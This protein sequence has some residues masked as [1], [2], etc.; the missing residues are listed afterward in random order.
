[1]ARVV[2][3]YSHIKRYV[4]ELE[5]GIYLAKIDATRAKTLEEDDRG[6][7]F[8][9]DFTLLEGPEEGGRLG[10]RIYVNGEMA[11]TCDQLEKALGLKA[12]FDTYADLH[13]KEVRIQT[14]MRES[15]GKWYVNVWRI[16]PAGDRGAAALPVN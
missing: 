6:T 2:P 5:D 4:Q 14:K 3:D 11:F 13:G 8:N 16:L 10:H 9:L 15:G 7:Y 12:P 1:M